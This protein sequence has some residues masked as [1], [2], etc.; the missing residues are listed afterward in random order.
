MYVH[1][2][3]D[4]YGIT[5]VLF[6]ASRESM[7]GF[8]PKHIFDTALSAIKSIPAG[9][10]RYD[11]DTKIWYVDNEYWQNL[12]EFFVKGSMLYTLVEHRDDDDFQYVI[13]GIKKAAATWSGPDNKAAKDFFRNFNN[14]VVKIADNR[15]DKQ[16][17]AELLGLQSFDN[18]PSDK[19][20]AKK[21][22]RAAA[23]K[24]HPDKNMGDGSKMSQLN[25]LWG[26]YVQPTL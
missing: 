11:P 3:V 25:S 8:I 21:L 24:L 18:I 7:Q 12:R 9:K 19:N 22:Y 15:T 2:C 17:L 1:T 6:S 16:I 10:R 4:S 5:Q 20:A 23:I 26:Q 14:V 13:T